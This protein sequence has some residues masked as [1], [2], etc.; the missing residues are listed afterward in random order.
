VCNKLLCRLTILFFRCLSTIES[1]CSACA[2]EHGVICEI[3][4]DNERMASQHDIFIA[5]VQRDGFA[6]VAGAF[7]RGVLNMTKIEDIDS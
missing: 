5:D 6:A 1:E 4:R 2:R 7:S 3:R